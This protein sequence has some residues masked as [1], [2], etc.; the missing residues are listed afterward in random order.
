MVSEIGHLFPKVHYTTV[1]SQFYMWM[2]GAGIPRHE[3][4]HYSFTGTL[5]LNNWDP[6]FGGWFIWKDEE[7]EKTGVHKAFY[8]RANSLMLSDSFE[9]HWVTQITPNAPDPRVTIQLWGTRND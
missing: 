2:R 5:Y 4:H 3:G 9:D 8:P 1:T 7:T 6:N